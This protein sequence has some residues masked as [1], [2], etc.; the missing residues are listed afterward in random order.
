MSFG[1]APTI[2]VNTVTVEALLLRTY[3]AVSPASLTTWLGGPFSDNLQQRAA[4]RFAVEG[5]DDGPWA[6]L[7]S[8]TLEIRHNLGYPP[9]PINYRSGEMY[10]YITGASG[11]V[12]ATGDGAALT[13]P[14]NAP[15]EIQEK[16]ATAQGYDSNVPAREVIGMG[17]SDLQFALA[18]LAGWISLY[19]A[20]NR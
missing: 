16:I 4:E 10:R 14:G 19:V 13:W 5:T 8:A 1:M 2:F 9:G 7:A 12:V 20:G 6:A 11:Q 3:A 15:S 18:S 17:A